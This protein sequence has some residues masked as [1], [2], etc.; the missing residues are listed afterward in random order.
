[1][2]SEPGRSSATGAGKAWVTVDETV[3]GLLKQE[4]AD[5]G[6]FAGAVLLVVHEGN[7]VKSAAYGYAELFDRHAVPLPVP[8]AMENDTVFDLAS[9]SKAVSTANLTA[10]LF[11]DGALRLTDP[12]CRYLSAFDRPGKREIS[13]AHLL[14]H[15]SGLTNWLP[16]YLLVD[17]G[18]DSLGQIARLPQTYTPGRQ[19]C[20]SDANFVVL[21]KL[22]EAAAGVALD[23]LFE[24]RIAG[25]LN[26]RHSRYRPPEAWRERTAATSLG[27][28]MEERMCSERT[29]PV[30]LRRGVKDLPNWRGHVLKA[31][32]ND[33]NCHLVFNGVAGHAG[34]FANAED[35]VKVGEAML[36]AVL[37]R[38]EAWLRRDIATWFTT[39]KVTPGQGL[40]WWTNRL[41]ESPRTFGHQGFTGTQLF[42]DPDS[43]LVTV[44][45]TNRVHSALPYAEPHRFTVPIM[46]SVYRAL[47][48]ADELAVDPWLKP[49]AETPF[50]VNRRR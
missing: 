36:D 4:A 27:N 34:L 29:F 42:I 1:M 9:I 40:G 25:P 24:E 10:L 41:S 17:N 37:G 26:L 50:A 5:D 44:L 43:D 8:R 14:T 2:S 21:G 19:R 18:D 7:V 45:L 13:V 47:Q 20:Y 48:V 39:P 23:S 16:F 46:S 30:D 32:V 33:A 49:Q 31:E 6:A 3:S 28:R 15:S 12:I 22:I 38:D 35:L 11:Q